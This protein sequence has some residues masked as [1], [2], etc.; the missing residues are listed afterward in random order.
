MTFVLV[1]KIPSDHNAASGRFK[2]RAQKKTQGNL[3]HQSAGEND[4][5]TLRVFVG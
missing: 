4:S 1:G 5:G 3:H 2:P